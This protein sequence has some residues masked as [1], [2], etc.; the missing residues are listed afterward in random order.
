[1]QC[2]SKGEKAKE[3]LRK[4]KIIK[5]RRQRLQNEVTATIL[6]QMLKLGCGIFFSF[7][8]FYCCLEMQNKNILSLSFSL[9]E[10]HILL[11]SKLLYAE[12][13]LAIT[14]NLYSFPL[15]V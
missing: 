15:F 6:F 14:I 1:M 11:K 2:P 3:A 12:N 9:H 13:N 10:L 7:C 8:L 4:K 5:I